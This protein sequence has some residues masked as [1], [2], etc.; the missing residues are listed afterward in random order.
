MNSLRSYRSLT[1]R[2]IKRAGR[3]FAAE[4]YLCDRRGEAARTGPAAVL[5]LS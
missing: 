1:S 5:D 2:R 3:K 4:R